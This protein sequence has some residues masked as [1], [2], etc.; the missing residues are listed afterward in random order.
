MFSVHGSHQQSIQTTLLVYS[1][2][3]YCIHILY[4]IFYNGNHPLGFLKGK[5]FLD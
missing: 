3:E 2:S 4:G 5:E 1:F